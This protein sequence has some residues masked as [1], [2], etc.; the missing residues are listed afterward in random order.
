MDSVERVFMK[1]YTSSSF[2]EPIRVL[3]VDQD[4][5]FFKQMQEQIELNSHM[6]KIA[7]KHIEKISEA[8]ESMSAW[9]PNLVV[10]DFA[11]SPLLAAHLM[12]GCHQMDVP[13]VITGEVLNNE[14]E[15]AARKIGA[16]AYV[17]KSEDSDDMDKI[18]ELFS[19][20]A[21]ES[22]TFH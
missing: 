14:V 4:P 11:N 17:V 8:A 21:K 13:V 5:Y 12:Q 9:N 15:S 10:L 18:L 6:F 2:S 20:T 7:F 16:T 3:I 22:C 1:S 19:E